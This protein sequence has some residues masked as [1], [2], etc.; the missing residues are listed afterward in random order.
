MSNPLIRGNWWQCWWDHPTPRHFFYVLL[1]SLWKRGYYRFPRIPCSTCVLLRWSWLLIEKCGWFGHTLG[2]SRGA[3]RWSNGYWDGDRYLS[4]VLS[5]G[6][7]KAAI[8]HGGQQPFNKPSKMP[9]TRWKENEDPL[10]WLEGY[11]FPYISY[12]SSGEKLLKYQ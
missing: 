4:N 3:L 8:K 1:P 11:K 12:R 9:W 2:C 5:G 10:L 7:V 6:N